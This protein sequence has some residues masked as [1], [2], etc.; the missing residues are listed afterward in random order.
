M[1]ILV[2]GNAQQLTMFKHTQDGAERIN[3]LY[4]TISQLQG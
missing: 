4:T 1:V 3:V 2:I